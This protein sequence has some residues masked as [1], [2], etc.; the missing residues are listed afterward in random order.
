DFT[1]ALGRVRAKTGHLSGVASLAGY[2]D[3]RHHG[4]LAFAF[5]IDGSPAD[6]DSAYVHAVD[7]L[8]EF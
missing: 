4:R 3:T 2:V 1:S 5:L 8:S 7:R 6:P